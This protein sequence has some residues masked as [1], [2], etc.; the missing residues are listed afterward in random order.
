MTSTEER[1]LNGEKLKDKYGDCYLP[2]MIYSDRETTQVICF[3][4]GDYTLL[5]E[6]T[7]CAYS[8]DLPITAQFWGS[9]TILLE[10]AYS[11]SY[12]TYNNMF[13]NYDRFVASLEAIRELVADRQ[14]R[15]FDYEMLPDLRKRY[16][17]IVKDRPV[18]VVS[19]MTKRSH[20]RRTYFFHDREKARNLYAK[21]YGVKWRKLEKVN[22]TG[23]REVISESQR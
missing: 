20:Q 8:D 3:K 4:E 6:A 15:N 7:A 21:L 9:G 2:V 16:L 11:Y 5:Y 1:V 10:G 18:Y 19:Y 23:G 14:F 22:K 12:T 17:Q 13:E